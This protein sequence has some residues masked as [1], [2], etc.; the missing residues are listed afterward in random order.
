MDRGLKG[1]GRKGRVG[2]GRNEGNVE[3][4]VKHSRGERKGKE[5]KGVWRND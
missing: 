2:K 4:L 1:R 3:R 5:N